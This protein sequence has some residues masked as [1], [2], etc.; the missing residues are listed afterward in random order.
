[1]PELDPAPIPTSPDAIT[2]DEAAALKAVAA[3]LVRRAEDAAVKQGWLTSPYAKWA[4]GALLTALLGAG[5][6]VAG[7]YSAT[8][9]EPAPSPPTV[10]VGKLIG[11]GFA[12]LGG[13]LKAIGDKL[14]AIDGKIDGKPAP[15]PPMPIPPPEPDDWGEAALPLEVKAES[16]RM[17]VVEAK[18]KG[19]CRWLIPP[20]SPCDRFESGKKLS[21][22][23]SAAVDFAVGVVSIP[24]GV[25]SWTRI[26]AAKP[27]P[28]PPPP[29]PKPPTPPVSP[30]TAK[31]KAA[32]LADAAPIAVKAGQMA[33]LKGLYE[34]MAD[35][36]KNPAI[37][38]TTD[39]LADLRA[40]SSQMIPPTALVEVRKA[41]SAEINL[42]LGSTPAAKLDPDLRPRAVD[43]FARIAKSLGE[44]Q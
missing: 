4:I 5:G 19:D 13:S 41:I 27:A 3:K 8:A 38:T 33:A 31:L 40:V 34:A 32:Y 26:K 24:D 17:I 39:L 14:A 23:P 11:D 42:S 30:L 20:D 21:L 18:I 43:V 28:V 2:P 16:G 9:P 10:D 12:S 44:A 1:M 7:R 25:V 35:H 29:D 15:V 37:V 22:T 6:V 36:A